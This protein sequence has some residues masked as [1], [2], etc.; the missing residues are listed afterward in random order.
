M[1]VDPEQLAQ[2]VVDRTL[3]IGPEIASRAAIGELQV[4]GEKP[5]EGQNGAHDRTTCRGPQ[6]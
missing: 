5:P 2:G 4:V 3:L 1:K 6:R